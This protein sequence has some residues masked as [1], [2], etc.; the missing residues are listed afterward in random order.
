MHFVRRRRVRHRLVAPGDAIAILDPRADAGIGGYSHELA[1]GLVEIG[2]RVSVY[3]PKAPF[4]ERL[5]RRYRLFPVLGDHVPHLRRAQ[6][7][8][9]IVARAA[10]APTVDDGTC[11][12]DP[13]FRLLA[14]R[15]PSMCVGDAADVVAAPPSAIGQ[16]ATPSN[17][18]AS[19]STHTLREWLGGCA[20]SVELADHLRRERY[21]L[22]WTQWPELGRYDATFRSVCRTFGLRTIHTVHNVL[23]HERAP[24]DE[25][26]HK[27]VYRRS[28]ALIVHSHQ[29]ARTLATAF[30]GTGSKIV[31]SR[32]GLYT[33]Y[34]RVPGTRPRVRQ[35]L[36]LDDDTTAILFFGGVRPY[37]NLDRTLEALGDRR[38]EGI[39]LIVAGWEWGYPD[40]V[41]RDRLGRARRL[42]SRLGAGARVRLLPG[43]FGVR[44]TAELF[45]ASD[46][47]I[48]PYLQ[49]YGSGLLCMGLTYGKHVLLTRAGGM[50]E[51]VSAYRAH[52]IL[53]DAGADTIADGMSSARR[54]IGRGIDAQRPPDLEWPVIAAEMLADIDRVLAR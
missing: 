9:P 29:T 51:Y 41:A 12:L 2:M 39:V 35:H 6:A 21:R 38:C 33:I 44:Q 16:P 43:P 47:V 13:Y 22:V 15:G 40:L 26:R 11:T 46:A 32:H 24:G 53:H 50:E 25:A 45:E 1:E 30:P 23:P 14:E 52:T 31:T 5:A 18:A 36:Q 17:V 7:P 28:E 37:K 8:G 19:A 3:T 20:L 10:P 34:P 27:V 54:Q 42:A 49:S 4:S 48:L